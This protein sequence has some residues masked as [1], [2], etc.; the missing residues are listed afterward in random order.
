M[1][2]EEIL[3]KADE[4][5]ESANYHSFV[6]LPEK[7]FEAVEDDLLP[8]HKLNAARAIA[9]AITSCV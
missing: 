5:L 7:V 2:V 4:E 3:R 9:E 6:G 1:S 8:R